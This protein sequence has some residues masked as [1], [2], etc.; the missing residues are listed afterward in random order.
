MKDKV[1]KKILLVRVPE[2]EFNPGVHDLRNTSVGSLTVPM[3]IT[4]IASVIKEIDQY[5]VQILDLYALHYEE[6][7][8]NLKNNPSKVLNLTNESLFKAI[9][10][11]N[12]DIV[13]FSA[14]F[15]FQHLLVQELIKKTKNYRPELRIYLGGYPTIFPEMVMNNIPELDVLFIG[16]AD[17]S[18]IEVLNAEF[19]NL[20]FRSIKGIAVRI[21]D[22]TFINAGLNV[23]VDLDSIPFPAY[24]MLPLDIYKSIN[25]RVELPMMTSRGC[26]FDCNYCSG[27]LYSAR[28][29][30]MRSLENLIEEIELMHSK[31][32]VD[33][34][35]IRDDNLNVNKN[36]VKNFLKEMIKK[37]LNIPWCDTS[38]F[39]VNSVDEELLDLCKASGC[40][41]VIF[42]V[43]SGST[44]VLKD[45]MNKDVNLEHAKKMAAYCREIDLPLQCYFVIGN[46]GETKEEI[47]KTVEIA[48]ELQVNHCT[49]SIATPFPGTQYYELALKEG[50]LVNDP[51]YILGMKYME[52]NM[53]TEQFTSKQ[54]KD[55]QYDANMRVNFLECNMLK[56]DTQT[57]KKAL[58]QFSRIAHQYK[59]H[60]VAYLVKGYIQGLLGYDD[61]KNN[62]YRHIE[63]ML[64][65]DEIV[66]AYGKYFETWN[67]PAIND[68]REWLKV[69]KNKPTD[70]RY[71]SRI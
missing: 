26:P 70:L 14:P 63:E 37:S 62:T 67:I 20:D 16:E 27:H 30:R 45:I 17:N 56:G 19:D 60:A 68:Y 32:N 2:V 65:D 53:Q 15:S 48:L 35:W 31:Y 1:R 61:E 58:K 44:R 59:F 34:L 40:T 69:N 23:P 11:Y 10:D 43:E 38:S 41:E 55:I 12:P 22:E 64:K 39:H 50:Y 49:F 33:F 47:Q 57:L 13:G 54:L 29:F 24:D 8:E 66:D 3:G 46:P 52:A 28:K 42:A 18:I 51:D 9:D 5:D 36:H 21:N 71:T 4:Y 7:V 25:G 6:L